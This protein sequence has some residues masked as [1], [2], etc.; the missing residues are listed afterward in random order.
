MS[1]RRYEVYRESG[2][3]WLG[4]LPRHWWC[5]ALK[6]GFN[7]RLGKMLQPE[8][9]HS[10][11]ELC[12][13]LRAANIQ[14]SGVDLSDVRLMWFSKEERA[15]LEIRSGDLL[16]SEGG[17]VGR[18]ASWVGSG[19]PHYFQNSINRVRAH[20]E[21]ITRFVFYWIAMLKAS[22]YIDVLCNKATIAHFTAEKLASIEVA[23]P[24]LEEQRSIAAFLDRETAKIDALV[25]E[26]RRLIELLK[27][28]RQAVISHAVT[29]GLDPSAPMK[30]S[31][32][33]WLGEVPAHWE[34]TRLANAFREVAE[35]LLEELPILSVSIHHGVSDDELDEDDLER[36]VSRSEDRSK[37]KRVRPEDLVYNMMRAWQG[38][39]GTVSVDGGVSPAY[40]VARPTRSVETAFVEWVL[41]TSQCVE[42]MRTRSVGVTDF[43][44][45][46]YWEEFK[47]LKIA[48]PPISEQQQVLKEIGA[49]V[50][51]YQSLAAA[52]EAT[53]AF[54]RE[55]RAA[56]ISAAVTG[57]IDVREHA[58]E[59]IALEP[60]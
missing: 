49:Q 14:P 45:R 54:L 29:K 32:V 23:Y 31:G 1:F 3:A 6:R 9:R 16:V 52:A 15:A 47:D 10:T 51:R 2:V 42:E 55:R 44:L 34:V 4:S 36:K 28:K 21:H 38:G 50:A 13:Y 40:V 24:P 8:R 60:A 22:G 35:P 27:E 37:Y 20:D 48:L 56:L 17:D 5:G 18:A 33:E 12:P 7:V 57:K 26:Q 46:L 39:F 19:A 11:D 58:A 59:P 41:R 25:E 53:I 43:R 30:D